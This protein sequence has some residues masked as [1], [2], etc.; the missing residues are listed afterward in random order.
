M[1]IVMAPGSTEAD[2]ENV[3]KKIKEEGLDYHLSTGS[4]RTI[5]GVI[6]DKKA[7]SRLE[8]HCCLSG[9]EKTV[10]ITEKYKLVSRG[11]SRV[12]YMMSEAVIFFRSK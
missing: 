9:V 8:M 10:R 1:I 7:V 12:R 2:L 11:V 3:K 5:V 4:S 6:G